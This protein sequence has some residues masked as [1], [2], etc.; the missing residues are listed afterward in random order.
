LFLTAFGLA[1]FSNKNLTTCQARCSDGVEK[2]R[3]GRAVSGRACQEG[4]R[5]DYRA[6]RESHV[7]ASVTSVRCRAC[8]RVTVTMLC[9]IDYTVLQVAQCSI[10]LARCGQ[11]V[12]PLALPLPWQR[13]GA[14]PHFRGPSQI[15]LRARTR[16]CKKEDGDTQ[17]RASID[18]QGSEWWQTCMTHA[19]SRTDAWTSSACASRQVL[20]SWITHAGEHR[21]P[22][23]RLRNKVARLAYRWFPARVYPGRRASASGPGK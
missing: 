10:G 6:V 3:S 19:Y 16:A 9:S 7:D 17:C 13:G 8:K 21:L 14:F 18:W 15:F 2:K 22:V 12:I 1:P 20:E 5:E 11:S 23:Y 4:S